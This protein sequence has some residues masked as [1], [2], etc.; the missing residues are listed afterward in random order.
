MGPLCS[1]LQTKPVLQSLGCLAFSL[2]TSTTLWVSPLSFCLP[3]PLPSGFSCFLLSP[4]PSVLQSKALLP[5]PLPWSAIL[6]SFTLWQT[7]PLRDHLCCAFCPS[8]LNWIR[9]GDCSKKSHTGD[10]FS[11]PSCGTLL[12]SQFFSPCCLLKSPFFHWPVLHASISRSN[13]AE[14]W[15]Y[16]FHLW[17]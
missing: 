3:P 12:G 2:P 1:I 4:C 10:A 16:D 9:P 8:L 11:S 7:Y 6:P 15:N 5:H 13:F 17:M 14:P